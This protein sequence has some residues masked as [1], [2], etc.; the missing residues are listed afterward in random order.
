MSN[1]RNGAHSGNWKVL[2]VYYSHSGNTRECATQI[3][4]RVGGDLM[5]IIP[6]EPYPVDYDAVVA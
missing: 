5:E 6:V 4:Q 1:E 2:T 3:H